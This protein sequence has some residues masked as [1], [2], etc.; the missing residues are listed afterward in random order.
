MIRKAVSFMI[1][2]VLVTVNIAGGMIKAGAEEEEYKNIDELL[3]NCS[4]ECIAVYE[5]NTG[6][7]IG[8][9][10]ENEKRYISHLTKLMT[11]LIVNDHIASGELNIDE[12][13]KTSEYANSMQGVQIWLDVG[14]EITVDELI[15]AITI[16][17][18]NDAAVVLAEGCCQSE[19]KFVK[20]MNKRA[21]KLGMNN[22]SFA[23]CTG[24]SEKNISTARDI[25]ILIG[26]LA[27]NNVFEEYFKMRIAEVGRKGSQLVTQNKL[28][29]N[30]KGCCGYKSCY[31]ENEGEMLAAASKQRDMAVCTVVI[32]AKNEETKYSEAKAVTDFAFTHCEIYYPEIPA[33]ATADIE[34]EHGKKPI[35]GTEITGERNIIIERGTYRQI[36]TE[37]TREEIVK[38]PVSKG[39][40]I[41][42]LVFYNDKGEILRCG[43]AA[44]DNVEEMDI[45][46]AFKCLLYNLFNI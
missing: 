16:S 32:G 34:V 35:V 29:G 5:A 28:I 18:A 43:I 22:T 7:L 4:S 36:Y 20:E 10:N 19:E 30:Y 13:L 39:D 25:S 37:F 21:K 2:I 33:E 44:S 40:K 11:A 8:G 14:E 46:F 9:K 26:E 27:K 45:L 17:N 38:A 23:D 24:T 15:K 41:G 42:T 1:V 12:K 3:N 31:S 6:T